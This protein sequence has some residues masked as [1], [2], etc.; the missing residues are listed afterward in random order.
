MS[1]SATSAAKKRRAGNIVS[2]PLFKPTN[3]PIE[4]S[5]HRRTNMPYQQQ[6]SLPQQ[7]QYKPIVPNNVSNVGNVT[8]VANV[9][10]NSP[11]TIP[12]IS[13]GPNMQKPMSLQQ[14]ISVFDKRLLF[15]E[16]YILKNGD[17][18][19]SAVQSTPVVQPIIQQQPSEDIEKLKESIRENLDG[20]F[21]EFDHRYQLLATEIANLKQIVLKLQ[22]YTLEINQFLFEERNEILKKLNDV[23]EHGTHNTIVHD[24]STNTAQE[25]TTFITSNDVKQE[26]IETNKEETEQNADGE[27]EGEDTEQNAEDV[28]E[29]EQN[30]EA[31]EETEQNA[32]ALEETEQNAEALEETEQNADGEGEETEQNV[33][34]LDE[35]EQNV[36]GEGEGEEITKEIEEIEKVVQEEEY[37][38]KTKRKRKQ[39]NVIP[40]SI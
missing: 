21:S 19:E 37:V 2:S 18:K 38:E 12:D 17:M 28:K 7:P 24:V 8:N 31:L 14:V 15:I 22:S 26:F 29:T 20:Q 13:V 34:A 5:I 30:V 36:E 23:Q 10:N 4:N 39:K 11:Q 1:V 32:E 25:N 35:T 16:S 6:Q 3:A 33:E 27:G 40:L 9:S